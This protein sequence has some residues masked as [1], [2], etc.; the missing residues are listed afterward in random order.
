MGIPSMV[1]HLLKPQS[2]SMWVSHCGYPLPMDEIHRYPGS[3]QPTG[4]YGTTCLSCTCGHL[5]P[6]CATTFLTHITHTAAS[7]TLPT[8]LWPWPSC[9]PCPSARPLCHLHPP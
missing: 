6:T 1:T 9:H 3:P 7:L 8:P 5:P 2:I 4:T